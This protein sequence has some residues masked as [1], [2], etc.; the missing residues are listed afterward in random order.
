MESSNNIPP[1]PTRQ[2]I[3]QNS[4]ILSITILIIGLVVG[5]GIGYAVT[6]SEFNNKLINSKV[7]WAYL[8]V[9]TLTL[10]LTF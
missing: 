5:S 7:N 9:R 2:K 8:A 4:L 10:K 1:L 6:Y 3:K